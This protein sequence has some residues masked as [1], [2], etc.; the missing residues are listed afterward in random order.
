M[1]QHFEQGF[2]EQVFTIDSMIK[3]DKNMPG[4]GFSLTLIFPY[5]DRIEDS[6]FMRENTDQGKPFLRHIIRND[7]STQCTSLKTVQITVV[8]KSQPIK[9]HSMYY[10]NSVEMFCPSSINCLKYFFNFIMSFCPSDNVR[11]KQQLYQYEVCLRLSY[12]ALLRLY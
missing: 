6:V 2:F 1:H 5:N 9:N 11:L 4:Y 12:L 8:Q 10:K 7:S 3:R